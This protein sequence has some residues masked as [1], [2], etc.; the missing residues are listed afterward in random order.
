MADRHKTRE[1]TGIQ[2]QNPRTGRWIQEGGRTFRNLLRAGFLTSA[3]ANE[4]ENDS[5]AL[6]AKTR[7]MKF[8][9]SLRSCR[10][11]DTKSPVETRLEDAPTLP[12]GIAPNRIIPFENLDKVFHERWEPH[13]D[14]L[15]IPHP[16][17]MLFLSKPNGGKTTL[18]LNMILRSAL[19]KYP[20]RRTLSYTA[21]Q[22]RRKS[23]QH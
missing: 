13:R 4:H 12:Q 15:D 1:Y 5:A 18:I 16:F 21:T 19:G 9:N 3:Y 11:D 22:N 23:I 6:L 20:F 17:R 14:W 7:S 10:A 8:S 2:I